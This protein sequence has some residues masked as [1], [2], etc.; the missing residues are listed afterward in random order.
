MS[1]R[2]KST[3]RQ[4]RQLNKSQRKAQQVRLAE[5]NAPAPIDMT[6]ALEQDELLDAPVAAP[7]VAGRRASRRQATQQVNY[8]LPRDVEYGYI[9]SDLRRLIITAGVLAGAHVRAALHS[10]LAAIH[11]ANAN[12]ARQLPR[13][14]LRWHVLRLQL[15]GVRV[16]LTWVDI[17]KCVEIVALH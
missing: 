12:G 16:V 11:A 13:A 8:V 3:K 14:V 4:N 5:T 9:R 6:V 1:D 2:S 10:R 17:A 7:V 15:D